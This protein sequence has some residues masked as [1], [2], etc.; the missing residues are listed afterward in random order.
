MRLLRPGNDIGCS[1]E[2]VYR[3]SWFVWE[4]AKM[5]RVLNFSE[6]ER[7]DS[8]QEAQFWDLFFAVTPDPA[9]STIRPSVHPGYLRELL[10]YSSAELDLSPDRNFMVALAGEQ[11][12]ARLSMNR[13]RHDQSLGYFGCFDYAIGS[14]AGD[15][16]SPASEGALGMACLLK[17]AEIWFREREISK[18]YGPV[19]LSTWFPYR[20]QAE[21]FAGHVFSWEPRTPLHYAALLGSEKFNADHHYGT[22]CVEG[23]A[24][25]YAANE[26]FETAALQAGFRFKTLTP[27]E[28]SDNLKFLYE[29]TLD[30][31]EG[32][33]LFEALPYNG[34]A[35]LYLAGQSLQQ[36]RIMV[37]LVYEPA[38]APVGFMLSQVEDGY[39]VLKTMGI[40]KPFRRHGLAFALAA[41][42]LRLGM[43]LECSK[44]V[45][46]LIF[47]QG[48]SM[49]WWLELTQSGSP[50]WQHKYSLF[51]KELI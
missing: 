9:H 41:R 5:F 36:A 34:F 48:K 45:G 28:H 35:K 15:Q 47:E 10:Q 12:V 49:S 46:A 7:G 17:H 44:L 42:A 23:I 38:G 11:P 24:S 37:D 39:L 22:Y 19:C 29:L 1:S 50:L 30:T 27:Q 51:S 6:L 18:L 14:G 13:T 2:L 21:E 32:N 40:R 4:V 25:V 33:F 8:A 20:L 16:E 26:R 31:F 3:V 43:E